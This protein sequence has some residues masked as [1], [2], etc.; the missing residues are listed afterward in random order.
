MF[1]VCRWSDRVGLLVDWV[2]GSA[3]STVIFAE[4]WSILDII[5][6]GIFAFTQARLA[7]VST[8]GWANT[9]H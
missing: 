3:P 6:S 1:I 2:N 8:E 7:N 9:Q 5:K 4:L